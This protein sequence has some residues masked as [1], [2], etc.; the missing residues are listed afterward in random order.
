MKGSGMMNN[1]DKE[2]SIVSDLR[3]SSWDIYWK[4]T[5]GCLPGETCVPKAGHCGI[6]RRL[7]HFGK[8]DFRYAVVLNYSGF[9]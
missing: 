2:Y 4:Y 3:L 8:L 1:I 9:L 7:E 6:L 5:V